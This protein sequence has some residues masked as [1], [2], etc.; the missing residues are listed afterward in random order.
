MSASQVASYRHEP[1]STGRFLKPVQNVIAILIG[2][3]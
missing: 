1:P 3:D 2:I